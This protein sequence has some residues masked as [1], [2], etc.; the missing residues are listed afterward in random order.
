[1]LVL[2]LILDRGSSENGGMRTVPSVVS[3]DDD[4]I[5]PPTGNEDSTSSKGLHIL[6]FFI[7]A[8][9]GVMFFDRTCLI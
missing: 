3:L 9:E 7:S 8:G 1:M 5:M 4:R 2:V 6:G